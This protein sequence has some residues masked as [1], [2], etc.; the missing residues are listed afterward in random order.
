MERVI[1]HCDLNNF[2]ANVACKMNPGLKG[3]PV[4]V[5]GNPSHRH[6]IVLAKSQEA[7]RYGVRTGDV[8]W[9][10]QR[11][12]PGLVPVLPD[13][14]RYLELSRDVQNIYRRYT[15]QVEPFGI[16]EC[17]LDVT[18]SRRLFGDGLQIADQL[19]DLVKQ[20]DLTIS[21]GVS[22]NKIFA[23]LGSD[24]NKPDGTTL[25]SP[26]NFH[27]VVWPLPVEELLMVGRATKKKLNH[28]GVYT[29]GDLAH[30]SVFTLEKLFG[31]NGRKLWRYAKGEDDS[32]VSRDSERAEAKSVGQGITC[33]HDLRS[34]EEASQIIHFL[35]QRVSRRL[36]ESG[37]L[38]G[39]LSLYLRRSDL[40]GMGHQTHFDQPCRSSQELAAAARELMD[41][42]Y[43]W[44]LPIR[45][46]S[47]QAGSL[48]AED[49]PDQ[50]SLW[51]LELASEREERLE[52]V[53]DQ[54]RRRFGPQS[55]CRA[56]LL[57][58]L[59]VPEIYQGDFSVLPGSRV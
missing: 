32:P 53:T 14:P 10:A 4:A 3:K 54:L 21:V 6:G 45:A 17:W 34:P 57:E 36:R 44:E 2:Y 55:I 40:S 19:R 29:I 56:S 30:S 51:D 22:F 8:L 46:I 9:E 58:G 37:V 28:Y 16:D 47:L 7:K 59:A 31:V 23:K 20:M 49:A 13:F 12:C 24:M 1:L 11:K 18:G 43:D 48:K 41:L 35:A 52:A 42:Y 25:I 33:T 15:D 50:R 39:S 27:Q 26:E 5:C 38:A